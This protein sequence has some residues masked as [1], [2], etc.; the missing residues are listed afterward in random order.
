M[1]PFASAIHKALLLV[2]LPFLV[3][4]AESSFLKSTNEADTGFLSASDA[5]S[6]ANG[7]TY[8][9]SATD[10]LTIGM[11]IDATLTISSGAIDLKQSSLL[12]TVYEGTEEEKERCTQSGILNVDVA[13]MPKVESAL[14][15][16]WQIETTPSKTCTDV[17]AQ[18]YLGIGAYNPLLDSAVTARGRDPQSLDYSVYVMLDPQSPLW[19]FGVADHWIG[20]SAQ[21][22][23]SGEPVTDSDLPDG[24]YSI[25]GMLLIPL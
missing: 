19:V 22:L 10:T 23:D 16:W 6:T 3:H 12:T 15:G 17:P 11:N 25:T 21:Q 18:L 5:S 8:A 2:A 20:S 4:C 7:A 24:N 9:P 1:T 13:D 14:Y